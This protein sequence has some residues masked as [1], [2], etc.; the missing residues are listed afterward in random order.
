[1]STDVNPYQCTS[2][3]PLTGTVSYG[4][5][6]VWEGRKIRVRARVL[7]KYLF[8]VVGYFVTIDNEQTF[9]SSQ[10]RWQENF[11]FRFKHQGR[12]A[13]GHF[14][15]HGGIWSSDKFS[16]VIDREKVAVSKV[17]VEGM[18]TVLLTILAIAAVLLV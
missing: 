16:L 8:L 7:P 14:R 3:L 13:T 10:V 11:Y 1:M 17:R 5:P 15:T 18:W 9:T 12:L 2:S 4:E 6:I